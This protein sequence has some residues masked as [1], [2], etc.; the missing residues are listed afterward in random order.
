MALHG[1]GKIISTSALHFSR[2]DQFEDPLEGFVRKD[3]PEAI[4]KGSLTFPD[5]KTK[6]Y[7]LHQVAKYLNRWRY[8]NCWHLNEFESAAMWKLYGKNDESI[9]IKTS[10][11]KL[12]D[13]LPPG[14]EIGLVK[15]ID[16]NTMWMPGFGSLSESLIQKRKSFSHENEV[17]LIIYHPEDLPRLEDGEPDFLR[18][19]NF[20]GCEVKVELG[21]LFEEIYISPHAPAWFS[22][23]VK[24]VVEKYEL[25]SF[26]KI[27]HSDLYRV[28]T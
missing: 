7:P 22:Q 27:I 18:E 8:V 24:S 9:A 13:C 5:K 19:N 28:A 11:K 4:G 20:T 6:D 26:V 12:T 17:R 14:V 3:L 25:D 10:Y 15:Y 23:V 21:K 2:P 1:F 16:F